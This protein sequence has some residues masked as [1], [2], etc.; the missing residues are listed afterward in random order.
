MICSPKYSRATFVYRDVLIALGTQ[1]K[2]TSG[3][4]NFFRRGENWSVA[5]GMIGLTGS[6][7]RG[8]W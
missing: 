8:L 5:S 1:F 7:V 3:G 6:V 4:G 2:G